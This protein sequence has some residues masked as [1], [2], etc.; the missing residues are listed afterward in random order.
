MQY[1]TCMI[2]KWVFRVKEELVTRYVTVN[3][4]QV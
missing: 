3:S 1:K 4:S 2:V